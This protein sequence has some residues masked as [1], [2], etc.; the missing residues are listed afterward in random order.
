MSNIICPV[1]SLFTDTLLSSRNGCVSRNWCLPKARAFTRMV[2]RR[3]W[4][5]KMLS[6]NGTNFVGADKLWER[7][8][9]ISPEVVQQM[10]A[11]R[12]VAWYWNPPVA[13]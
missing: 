5:Q 12:G 1:V 7:V 13:P 11:N 9:Q 2:A 10:N 3:G 6:D 4:S 8:E